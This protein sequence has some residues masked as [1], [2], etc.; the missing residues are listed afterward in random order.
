MFSSKID[1]YEIVRKIKYK[2]IK[3]TEKEIKLRNLRLFNYNPRILWKIRKY[4]HIED[5]CNTHIYIK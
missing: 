2:R 3:T 1:W 4:K 5:I